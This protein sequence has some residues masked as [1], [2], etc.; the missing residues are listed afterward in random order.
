MFFLWGGPFLEDTAILTIQ[1][2]I[3]SEGKQF[4]S[5]TK[6]TLWKG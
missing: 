4:S 1:P 5:T 6:N 2:N 3:K